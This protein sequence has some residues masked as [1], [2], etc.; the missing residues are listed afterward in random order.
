MKYLIFA[1][2]LGCNL[3]PGNRNRYTHINFPEIKECRV[4]MSSIFCTDER[5][6]HIMVDYLIY[7]VE[8]NSALTRSQKQELVRYFDLNRDQIIEDK[9]FEIN[10]AYH[11]FFR[12][13]Y[14]ISDEDENL[15]FNFVDEKL[16]LL[17]KYIQIYGDI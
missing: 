17:D 4:L 14:M 8:T 15:L 2:I 12:G 11:R 9:E 10:I 16:M 13:Y 6:D 7:K 5:M 1:L 3:G